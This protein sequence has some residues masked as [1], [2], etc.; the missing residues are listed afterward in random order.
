MPVTVGLSAI[1]ET[2]E[3][4]APPRMAMRGDPIGLQTP[5]TSRIDKVLVTLDVDTRVVNEAK[6]RGA[7]LIVAHHPVIYDKLERVT[8]TTFAEQVVMEAIRKEIGIYIAHTNLDCAPDGVN[9][10]LAQRLELTGVRP[11]SVSCEERH[12][13]VVVFVPEDHVDAVRAAMCGAGA[14]QIGDYSYCTFQTPGTGTFLPGAEASPFA[15]AVGKLNKE[16]ELRLEA[17]VPG[18][19]LGDVLAAMK[20]AHP[21]EEVAYDVYALQN[22]GRGYG[23]GRIGELPDAVPFKDYVELVK[24]RLGIKRVRMLGRG[25]TRIRRVA[26]CGGSGGSQLESVLA[27]R[28]DAFVT[29]EISYHAMLAA[30]SFSLCVVEAGHGATER[31]VLPVL[32]AKLQQRHPE[33]GVLTSRIKTDRSDWV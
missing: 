9:D 30:E 18:D 8:G 3:R 4:L 19:V 17:L 31:L 11:L 29:G 15:G 13:K 10:V 26:V 20:A 22:S 28:A 21:Y 33:I 7:A 27:Q 24:R 5:C 12:H 1:I 2:L 23:M 16:P 14:G 25:R 6:R 32:A